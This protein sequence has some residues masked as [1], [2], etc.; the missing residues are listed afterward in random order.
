MSLYLLVSLDAFN[1][2]QGSYLY[3]LEIGFKKKVIMDCFD[4]FNVVSNNSKRKKKEK[5]L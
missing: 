2:T 1:V 3:T 4:L 5:K